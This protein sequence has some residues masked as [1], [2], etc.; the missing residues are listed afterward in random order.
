MKEGLFHED[1]ALVYYRKGKPKHAGV[2][3]IDGAIYYISSKGRAV[4]GQ[5]IVHHEM[6]NGILKKGT[7]TFGEDYKLIPGS[8]VAPRKRK[9][10][11]NRNVTPRRRRNLKARLTEFFKKK[12]NLVAVGCL[13]LLVCV[14]AVA[15]MTNNGPE[16]DFVDQVQDST[17]ATAAGDVKFTVAGIEEEVLLCSVAAK[18]EYDG[19]LSLK[20]AVETGDPYRPVDFRYELK[21]ASGMLYVSEREDL[22]DAA[23]YVLSELQDGIEIHNL[24]VHTTYY[25]KAV[26]A[27]LVHTGSFTTA[28][29][30]RFVYIPGLVNT[31]D[32]GGYTTLDGRM[33]KQGLLIRGAEI[34]GLVNAA[35]FVPQSELENV[36]KTFGFRYDMDL[37]ENT[38]Y[39]GDYSSRLGVPHRFYTAPA[40]GEIFR[41]S[42]RESLRQIFCDLADPEKYPMY[43]HCTSGQNRT[44]TVVF[45]LQGVLNVSEE[46]MVREYQLT[47]Y[48][49]SGVIDS[50]NTDVIMSGLEPYAGDTTQEKIVSFLTDEIG[51]TR[52]EIESIRKIFLEG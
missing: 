31:R 51:V 36:Q 2:I 41:A 16:D 7:Y 21:N 15:S 44:G 28:Q 4:K 30:N 22:S 46:D 33:V 45:L 48:T 14:M 3:R 34:D 37:R 23:E 38:L 43:L 24:K 18:Q 27:D 25:Y 26:A 17:D 12:Q 35:S 5:H 49:S 19:E 32:I 29:S 20:T 13:V 50:T 52:K 39:N 10:K 1:G 11:K 42:N 40:Y 8:Y 9:N 47:G 6:C